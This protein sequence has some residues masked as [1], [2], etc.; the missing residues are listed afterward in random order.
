MSGTAKR[1]MPVKLSEIELDGDYAGWKFTGKTNPTI[2]T[3]EDLTSGDFGRIKRG[4][5]HVTYPPWD[6]VDEDGAPLPDPKPH[7]PF[8][9]LNKDGEE[10]PK[11]G[12]VYGMEVVGLLPFDLAVKMAEALS[13]KIGEVPGN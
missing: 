10:S 1:V 5:C 6:F 9:P 4:L 8:P 7:E 12:V 2:A 3:M 11:D 13:K